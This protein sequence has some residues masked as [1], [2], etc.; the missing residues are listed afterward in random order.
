M[1]TLGA[2][3]MTNYLS[4]RQLAT[5]FGLSIPTI[6]RWMAD[7][8]LPSTRIGSRI[9]FSPENIAAFISASEQKREAK[10]VAA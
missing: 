2:K 5:H 10:I 9:R 6:R 3:Q 8:L 7:G 4:V 1:N